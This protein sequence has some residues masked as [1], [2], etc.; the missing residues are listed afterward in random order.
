MTDLRRGLLAAGLGLAIVACSS[1]TPTPS[2]NPS[3]SQPLASGSL[4]TPKPGKTPRPGATGTGSPTADP[5]TPGDTPTAAVPGTPIPGLDQLTGSDGRFTMLVLGSDA[6]S[7]LVGERTDTIM[8]VT[9]DPATAKVSMVSLPRDMENVPIGPG[10]VY[11]P[12]VTG[13]F[14]DFSLSQ[15]DNRLQQ[16]HDMVNAI[17]YAFGIEIDRYALAHFDSVIRLIDAMGGIDVTLKRPFVDPSSHVTK[18]GLRLRAGAN[19]LN[20]HLALAF[21]RSR[22]TT[23]DYDRA[24]RQQLVISVAVAKVLTM[25]VD[26]LPA[27]TQLAFTN[28]TIET[29]VKLGDIPA[30]RALAQQARLS[31]FKSVVLGPNQYASGG[32]PPTY[33]TFMNVAAVRALFTRIFGTH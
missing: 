16:F 1:T 14:Q 8:V 10:Q 5:A 2:T 20:G 4:H 22:H 6:R 28:N 31:N 11:G 17:G 7:G 29:D 19:H 32:G 30:L 9:I 21:A 27:L 24:R 15:G 26:A 25:G 3:G 13:L 33:A 12:K 23:T 18:R